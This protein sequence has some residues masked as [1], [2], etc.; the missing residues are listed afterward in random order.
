MY[1]HLAEKWREIGGSTLTLFTNMDPWSSSGTWG[2]KEGFDDP[3]APKFDSVQAYLTSNPGGWDLRTGDWL[4]DV[5]GNGTLDVADMDLL[6]I[7]LTQNSPDDT[8]GLE[9]RWLG[10]SRRPSILGAVAQANLSWRHQ[11][12]RRGGDQRISSRCLSAGLY[13]DDLAATPLGSRGTGTATGS[14]T[15]RT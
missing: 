3:V 10:Q 15:A 7:A 14:S 9:P 4:G 5:N 6:A 1:T 11:P 13:E 8:L 2:L 12:G